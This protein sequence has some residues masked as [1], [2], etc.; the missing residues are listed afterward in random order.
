MSMC[1]RND[2]SHLHISGNYR[3]NR[4]T[5]YAQLRTPEFTENQQIIQHQIHKHGSHTGLHRHH[6]LPALPQGTGICR[7]QPKGQ[8]TEK[9]YQQIFFSI[10]QGRCQG[11]IVSF[12]VEIQHNQ[13]LSGGQEQQNTNRYQQQTNIQLVTEGVLHSFVVPAPII[14][15][16]KNTGTGDGTE[17]CQIKHQ[18]KLI[19]D[20]DTGHLL[21]TD[22]PH[23]NIVQKTHKVGNAV[24]NHNRYRHRQHFFVKFLRSY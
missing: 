1:P 2:N 11:R 5:C 14:L 16:A 15:G 21:R 9:H 4:G 17:D 3:G 19:Y 13:V 23:H 6:G 20:G 10:F 7:L 24:L 12:P 22:A 8:Q 18:Q